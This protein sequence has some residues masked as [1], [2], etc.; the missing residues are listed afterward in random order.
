MDTGQLLAKMI[1][2]VSGFF[3]LRAAAL[4]ALAHFAGTA[5]PQSGR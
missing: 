2:L 3:H 1:D 4:I 5:A